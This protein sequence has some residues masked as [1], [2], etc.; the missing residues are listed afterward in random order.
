MIV[1]HFDERKLDKPKLI[2]F[3]PQSFKFCTFNIL[4]GTNSSHK[5]NKKCI[6]NFQKHK[7]NPNVFPSLPFS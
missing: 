1:N 6:L 4:N 7:E 5:L 3:Q 2:K